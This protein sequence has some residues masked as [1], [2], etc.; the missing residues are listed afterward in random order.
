MA[1]GVRSRTI[2]A[3]SP[4]RAD[5]KG[6]TERTAFDDGRVYVH[7]RR[8][9]DPF[10]VNGFRQYDVATMLAGGWFGSSADDGRAK[11]R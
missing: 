5:R 1:P 6:Q 9:L 8:R 11:L 4:G 10:N 2:D 3:L 7:S